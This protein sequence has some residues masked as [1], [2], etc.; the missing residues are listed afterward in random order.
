MLDELKFVKGSVAKKDLL[1]ALTHFRIEASRIQGF[2]GKLALSTHID[3]NI[4]C[5]PKAS[6]LVNAINKC[7]ETIQLGMTKTGR[8]SIKS[9]KF[10]AY[11]ECVDGHTAHV[12]PEGTFVEVNGDMLL[13][14]LKLL[15]PFISDDAA[16]P[17]AN[18]VHFQGSSA[19]ATNNV[20]MAEHWLG[21]PFPI[22]VT[23][24]RDAVAEIVRIGK[25]PVRFQVSENSM[26]FHY[27][28]GKWAR[29]G[30]ISENEWPLE[31]IHKIFQD[32]GNQLNIP[33]EFFEGI[34]T[35]KPFT[36]R[37]NR[38]VFEKGLMRTH[39]LEF[40][41]GAAFELK[42][43]ETKSTFSLPMI[44][45]LAGVAKTIDLSKYPAPCPWK[46]E[47]IRGAIVGMH[48]IEGEI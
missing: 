6:S 33:D 21:S 9:G 44:L 10:R 1:P 34:D 30:L 38:V 46:G 12:E 25:A 35:L 23:I 15:Q 7:N 47:G 13:K 43:L 5:T 11:V 39:S 19:Y 14:A 2:N 28:D 22:S 4:D 45:K 40:E 31:G 41:E 18:G 32:S 8:L 36:D 42:W 48:W 29:C 20:V 17:W 24:P 3:F 27:D 16:R 37:Y 26:T